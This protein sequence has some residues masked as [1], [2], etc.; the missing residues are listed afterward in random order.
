M[1]TT[2]AFDEKISDE[3]AD[4]EHGLTPPDGSQFWTNLTDPLPI[5]RFD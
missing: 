2:G 5:L 1:M 3:H 4:I